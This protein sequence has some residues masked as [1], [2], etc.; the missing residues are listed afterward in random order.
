MG[1]NTNAGT[2]SG[3]VM[4]RSVQ[5]PPSTP[6]TSGN[7]HEGDI[8]TF[9]VKIPTNTSI[10]QFQLLWTADWG[11]Y[12]TNDLDMYVFDPNGVVDIDGATLNSPEHTVVNNPIPG[13]WTVLIQGFSVPTGQDT[14]QLSVVV[15]GKLVKLN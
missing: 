14:Y 8:L 13:T 10:A 7:I 6:S 5:Q 15:D 3:N 9:S 12:P 2:I 1:D 11:H 4:V